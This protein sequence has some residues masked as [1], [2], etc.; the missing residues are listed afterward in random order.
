VVS[1]VLAQI[2]LFAGAGNLLGDLDPAARGEIL[3]LGRQS[4]VR[5]A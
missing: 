4:L 2:A 5:G 3:Q 1:A